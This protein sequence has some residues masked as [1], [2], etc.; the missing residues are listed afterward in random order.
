MNYDSEEDDKRTLPICFVPEQL[1]FLKEFAKKKGMTSYS[2]AVEF[3]ARQN[4]HQ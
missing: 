4:N 2:Q 3:V 1:A